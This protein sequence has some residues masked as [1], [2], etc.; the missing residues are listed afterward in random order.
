MA[1]EF[2]NFTWKDAPNQETPL[3]ADNLNKLNN[4]LDAVD[5]KVNNALG[6]IIIGSTT[7]EV[8]TSTTDAGTAGKITFVLEA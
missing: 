2:T 7:Y 6:K 1:K 3:S 8:V 4:G 5:T